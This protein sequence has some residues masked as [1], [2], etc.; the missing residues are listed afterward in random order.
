MLIASKSHVWTACSLA[1]TL[2]APSGYVSDHRPAETTDESDARREG[3][4]AHWVAEGVL[5][6]DAHSC[7]D[8]EGETAPNGWIV[9]PDMV[10][11]AQGYCDYVRSFGPVVQAEGRIQIGEVITGRFDAH[12]TSTDPDAYMLPLRLFDFK[13]G[14]RI[15]EAPGN[16]SM[17]CYGVARWNGVQPVELHIYQPRPFHPAGPARVWKITPQEMLTLRA[18]LLERASVALTPGAAATPGLH[19]R[20]C[21]GA[22]SCHA[23][24]STVYAAAD[25]IQASGL[26]RMSAGELA[27]ELTFLRMVDKLVATRLAAVEAEAEGRLQ[28]CEFIP[29]W[30]M[31]DR[32][33]NRVWTVKPETVRMTTGLDPYKPVLKT[34]AELEREGAPPELLDMMTMTPHTGRKLMPATQD[35]FNRM[36]PKGGK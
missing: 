26:A 5:R 18:W 10:V 31:G 36:F 14:W 28:R 21:P 4:A 34:P 9:T 2:D 19:C 32:Y 22:A 29:G 24:A 7:A 25:T 6:G 33:G 11:H 27:R 16:T 35:F 8:F 12:A 3:K 1:G 17:L 30:L 15:V 20:D 13:Y 23:L